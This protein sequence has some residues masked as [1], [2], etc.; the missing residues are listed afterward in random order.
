MTELQTVWY[1]PYIYINWL[2]KI[3]LG[4][5]VTWELLNLY[6]SATPLTVAATIAEKNKIWYVRQLERP[7]AGQTASIFWKLKDCPSSKSRKAKS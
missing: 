4:L 3:K 1:F 2:L 5:A 7:K 6:F